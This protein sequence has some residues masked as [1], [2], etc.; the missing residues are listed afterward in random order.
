MPVA[1]F[2]TRIDVCGQGGRFFHFSGIR[3]LE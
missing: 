2:V 3:R 1:R